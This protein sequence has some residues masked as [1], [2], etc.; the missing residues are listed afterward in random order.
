MKWFYMKD[1]EQIGPLSPTSLLELSTCGAIDEDTLVRREDSTALSSLAE[2]RSQVVQEAEANTLDLSQHP[3]L[4]KTLS[5]ASKIS[6]ATGEA[7]TKA[8]QS[9]RA[10]AAARKTKE[11]A[12]ALG[13]NATKMAENAINSEKTLAAVARVK[14]EAVK[15]NEGFRTFLESPSV[16]KAKVT[17]LGWLK[18][19]RGKV[20][21]ALFFIGFLILRLMQV[22]PEREGSGENFSFRSSESGNS[23]SDKQRRQFKAAG[24]TPSTALGYTL[25]MRGYNDTQK[26]DEAWEEM[27]YLA[28]DSDAKAH[29]LIV[30]TGTK[31][32]REGRQPQLYHDPSLD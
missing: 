13:H 27:K 3:T 2:N 31:D 28:D 32:R 29:A 21:V 24:R 26:G 17:V 1:E 20:T 18:T 23:L 5:T 22:S 25:Y 7:I 16:S 12:T 19:R 30:V 6:T 15:A 9:E 11:G 8:R 10:Q 14:S 4:A